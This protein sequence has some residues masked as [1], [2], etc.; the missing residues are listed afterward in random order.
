MISMQRVT[1]IKR[2]ITQKFLIFILIIMH[3][4]VAHNVLIQLSYKNCIILSYYTSIIK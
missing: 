2:H 3:F 4:W 1:A